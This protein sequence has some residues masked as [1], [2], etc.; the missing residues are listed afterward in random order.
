MGSRH[1]SGGAPV[2]GTRVFHRLRV[3]A[4]YLASATATADWQLVQGDVT[5]RAGTT[6]D[7]LIASGAPHSDLRIDDVS[8]RAIGNGPTVVSPAHA[9]ATPGAPVE[10]V[11]TASDPTGEPIRAL[12]ADLSELLANSGATFVVDAAMGAAFCDGHRK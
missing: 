11:V 4:T 7:L 10:V 3:R 12:L 5:A 6:L 9:A 1:A 2:A 8:V